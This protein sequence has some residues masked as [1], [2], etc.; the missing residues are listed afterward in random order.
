MR[1][2]S[3]LAL[4]WLVL[5][6]TG[7]CV[8]DEWDRDDGLWACRVAGDA[9]G[10]YTMNGGMHVFDIGAAGKEKGS[11]SHKVICINPGE[12]VKWSWPGKTHI[13][14][15]FLSITQDAVCQAS[16][17]PFKTA[18]GNSGVNTYVISDAADGNYSGCVYEI[19]FR[20][21]DAPGKDPHV[22][23]KGYSDQLINDLK[24]AKEELQKVGATLDKNAEN[25][26]RLSDAEDKI[27]K[28]ETFLE[29]LKNAKLHSG[30]E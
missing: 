2:L 21:P 11:S 29:R 18:P 9:K 20:S 30:H 8:A 19:T 23:I 7:I 14:I 6:A 3:G 27:Q 5:S 12:Q 1:T 15:M 22:I 24:L 28:V 26:Q 16:V 13:D 10:I 17:Q 4:M 25:Q